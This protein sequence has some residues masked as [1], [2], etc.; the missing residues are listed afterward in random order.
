[1][2]LTCTWETDSDYVF[3]LSPQSL[4]KTRK[5]HWKSELRFAMMVALPFHIFPS[6]KAVLSEYFLLFIYCV[7]W[8]V[9]VFRGLWKY[10]VMLDENM[11]DVIAK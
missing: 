10:G 4:R 9:S 1:M 2:S 3:R 8:I 11:G 7:F 6:C 5:L